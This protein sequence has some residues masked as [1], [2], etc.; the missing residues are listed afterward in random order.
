[1][2]GGVFA[3]KVRGRLEPRGVGDLAVRADDS[4]TGPRLVLAPYLSPSVCERLREAGLSFLD[5]AGNSRIELEEP[6]LLLQTQGAKTN[7]DRSARPSRSLRGPKAGRIMRLL[8]DAR[9]P[10]GVRELAARAGVNAGYASRIVALLDREALVE[11]QGYGRIVKADWN[12]LLRRW[13]QDAPLESRG[14]QIT[15]L[16]PRGLG[17][18]LVRLREFT[19]RY[20]LTG[21]LAVEKLAPVA[22][23][24]MAML[25][26]EDAAEVMSGL[27]L[28]SAEAGANVVLIEPNDDGVFVGASMRDGLTCVATSQ[29]AVDLLTSPGRGPTEAEALITWMA[30]HEDVWRG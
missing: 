6:G 20:A 1:M 2:S 8:I 11:R 21:T 18:L 14:L 17:V 28:R 3:V 19:G 24:R 4:P 15:S 9:V 26:L 30:E 16:E 7:P 12:R 10:P 25:Y 5:L 23:S 13:A 29:A 27:G 22:P